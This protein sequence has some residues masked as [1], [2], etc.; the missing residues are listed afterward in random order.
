MRSV[1]HSPVVEFD[2]ELVETIRNGAIG[3]GLDHIDIVSSAGHD[4]LLE[5]HRIPTAVIFTPCRNGISHNE[6][7]RIKPEQAEAGANV[8]VAAVRQVITE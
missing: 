2:A 5:A 6:A 7:E 3:L 1:W 4:A 8:L